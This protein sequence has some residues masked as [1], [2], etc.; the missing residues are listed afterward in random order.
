MKYVFLGFSGMGLTMH[1]REQMMYTALYVM[2]MYVFGTL[3]ATIL[4]IFTHM[5]RS[6]VY[7]GMDKVLLCMEMQLYVAIKQEC[8]NQ[9]IIQSFLCCIGALMK[10]SASEFYVT[11]S[12]G[13]IRGMF[14]K[15]CV[16]AMK[17]FRAVAAVLF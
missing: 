11:E 17:V 12:Y 16:K 8:W 14:G 9:H 2:F 10:G 7:V 3:I 6:M 4:V 5:Q 15:S 1:R 13:G